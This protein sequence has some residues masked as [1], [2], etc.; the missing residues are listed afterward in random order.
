MVNN[1]IHSVT[2]YMLTIQLYVYILRWFLWYKQL[3]QM[4]LEIH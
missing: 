3:S 4:D 2:Q 1:M